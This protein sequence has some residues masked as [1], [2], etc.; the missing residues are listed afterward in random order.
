MANSSPICTRASKRNACS[1]E[2]RRSARLRL[3]D[4]HIA[5]GSPQWRSNDQA[6]PR[7]GV[8]GYDC[9]DRRLGP[10]PK[11]DDSVAPNRSAGRAPTPFVDDRTAMGRTSGRA[12]PEDAI[13]VDR[14]DRCARSP[15]EA[16]SPPDAQLA[17]RTPVP[18]APRRAQELVDRP[19]RPS[20]ESPRA[21]RR[22]AGGQQ[23]VLPRI[24]AVPVFG[25]RLL[26][27]TGRASPFREAKPRF[28]C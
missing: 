17:R 3:R 19:P 6:F 18:C 13:A 2:A 27:L 16:R 20:T 9:R 22:L 25:F 23:P 7:R 10:R 15:T 11:S 12:H 5:A 21:L 14:R 1:C 4:R 26:S 24:R 28:C 8:G